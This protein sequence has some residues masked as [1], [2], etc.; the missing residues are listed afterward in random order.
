[1]VATRNITYY[2]QT[3]TIMSGTLFKKIIY[4]L[5]KFV[6]SDTNEGA[7]FRMLVLFVIC[8]TVGISISVWQFLDLKDVGSRSIELP[9][10]TSVTQEIDK[11]YIREI[12]SAFNARVELFSKRTEEGIL[13]K[14]PH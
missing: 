8:S 1:M 3:N 14:D 10:T 7:W 4:Y 9:I 11:E 12:M 2:S 13:I 6:V 5:K